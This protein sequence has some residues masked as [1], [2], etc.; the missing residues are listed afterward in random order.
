MILGHR[1]APDRVR[2]GDRVVGVGDPKLQRGCVQRGS[3]D[4][5]LGVFETWVGAAWVGVAWVGAAWVGAAWVAAA[6]EG[7]AQLLSRNR[8]SGENENLHR[9]EQV[10][11]PWGGETAVQDD[12]AQRT[13]GDRRAGSSSARTPARGRS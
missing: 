3:Y 9:G 4:L 6:V 12:Q 10:P 8:F 11:R 13:S 1:L 7:R 2:L 5:D